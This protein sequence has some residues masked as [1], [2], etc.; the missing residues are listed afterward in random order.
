MKII[1]YARLS[2]ASREE[3]TSIARQ[4]ELVRTTCAARGFTLVEIIEDVDVS[5]TKSRLDRPGLNRVRAMIAAGEAEAVMVWRLDRLVRSVSDVGV[6]LDEGLQIISATE[7]LDTTS[8][9]G[10]AM[11]EIL[12]VFAS[13]EA[14]TTGL[15]VSASQ[16]FL[17]RNGRWAGGVL[18]YGYRPVP[19]PNGPGWALE[20]HPEEALVV[21]RIID[22]IL[23]GRSVYA[24]TTDLNREGIP[25]RR[26]AAWAT[27]SV[28][29]LA[30]SNSVLGRVKVRGEILRDDRGLPVVQWEPLVRVEDVE[31]VRVL[32]DWKSTPGRAA[33]TRAGRNR[34]RATRL[35]SGLIP[36]PGCNEPL[37]GKSRAST[38]GK[39]VYSCSAS[40]Q[41]RVCSGGIAVVCELVEAEV[42]RQFLDRWGQLQ[43]HETVTIAQEAADVAAVEESI[44]ATTDE[45]RA[46]DADL[47][48]LVERLTTLRAERER[49]LALPRQ[50]RSEI[51]ATGQTVRDAWEDLDIHDRRRLL[52]GAQVEIRVARASRRGFWD[53]DRVSVS[54]EEDYLLAS[55]LDS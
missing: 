37:V 5:A 47:P 15:R 49:V 10:R 39:D 43:A 31:R 46:E 30:R 17:R 41:G 20:P 4:R 27:T 19:N 32:T 45:L 55:D 3:S 51:R 48:A 7:S 44:R 34:K 22:E 12:Q 14:K 53:A 42:D 28:Q 16:E 18:P 24:V 8:I 50:P 6:L 23:A 26:G 36:C 35:L 21:R 1:G 33:A 9:M 40:A 54:R 38:T 2:R 11:V 13:M 25:P 52:V 29:R